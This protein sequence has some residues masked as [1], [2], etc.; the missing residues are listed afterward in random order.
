MQSSGEQPWKPSL[1]AVGSSTETFGDLAPGRN[2]FETVKPGRRLSEAGGPE[3]GPGEPAVRAASTAV[4]RWAF[5]GLPPPTPGRRLGSAVVL[6]NGQVVPAVEQ[7]APLS[8]RIRT[9]DS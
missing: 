8:V 5:R 9:L 7:T 6:S 2:G 3:A 1:A 4:N